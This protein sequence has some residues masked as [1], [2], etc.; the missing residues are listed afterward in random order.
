MSFIVYRH[1]CPNGKVYIGITHRTAKQRWQYGNGY[2]HN[3][4]FQ[5]AIH[6]YGWDNIKHEILFENLTKEDAERE[7]I[8]LISEHKSNQREFGYNQTAGGMVNMGFHVSEQGRKN[9]S[10]AQKGRKRT[11]EEIERM[12]QCNIGRHPSEETRAK[13][14]MKIPWN[15]GKH[16]VQKPSEYQKMRVAEVNRKRC[17][18]KVLCVE[19]GIIYPSIIEASMALKT[20]EGNI[21]RAISK[22]MRCA[23]FHWQFVQ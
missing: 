5:N 16:G 13:L 18:K 8:R 22:N 10:K 9:I 14:R 12:R 2:R 6:K 1:T 17:S 20:Y 3:P 11:P 4:R 19:T 15:K 7:E 23:G 21:S